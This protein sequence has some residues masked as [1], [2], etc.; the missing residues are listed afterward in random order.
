[1]LLTMMGLRVSNLSN[2]FKIMCIIIADNID[3]QLH[4]IE[5]NKDHAQFMIQVTSGVSI[6]LARYIY[7]GIWSELTYIMT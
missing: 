3:L 6:D 5:V 7:T 1:M 4:K 2:F